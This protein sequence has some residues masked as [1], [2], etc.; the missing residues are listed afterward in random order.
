MQIFH[1]ISILNRHF[2][3][4]EFNKNLEEDFCLQQFRILGLDEGPGYLREQQ[5][6]GGHMYHGGRDRRQRGRRCALQQCIP[7]ECNAM[8]QTLKSGLNISMLF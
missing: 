6:S 4:G 8:A 3:N 5:M 2:P 1:H 7:C